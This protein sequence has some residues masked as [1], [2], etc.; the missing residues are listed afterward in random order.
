[1]AAFADAAELVEDDDVVEEVAADVTVDEEVDDDLMRILGNGLEP[2][3][4]LKSSSEAAGDGIED[5]ATAFL[6]KVAPDLLFPVKLEV[7]KVESSLIFFVALTSLSATRLDFRLDEE[8][9]FRPEDDDDE[10][11]DKSSDANEDALGN[12]RRTPT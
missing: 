5:L 7:D 3:A 12:L 10:D 6:S 1:V 4:T 2:G 8:D 9:F 11:L